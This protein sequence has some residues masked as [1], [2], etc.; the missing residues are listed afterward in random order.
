MTEPDRSDPWRRRRIAIMAVAASVAV[1]IVGWAALGDGPWPLAVVSV[2]G[3]ALFG[4][5]LRLGAREWRAGMSAEPGV[6][7]SDHAGARIVVERPAS[8]YP[9]RLR[10]YRVIVDGQMVGQLLPGWSVET[11]VEPGEHV[12]QLRID[13]GRSRTVPVTVEPAGTARL[14]GEPRPAWSA[15]FW[16]TLGHRR[17]VRLR[18]A[19]A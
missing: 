13:W 11:P 18:P 15:L 7:P 12:V 4:H 3:A 5:G 9:D 17:Y 14:V 6:R 2:I 16:L 19:G 8:R 1:V 10:G